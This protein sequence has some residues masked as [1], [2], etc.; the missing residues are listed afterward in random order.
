MGLPYAPGN[1]TELPKSEKVETRTSCKLLSPADATKSARLS[2]DIPRLNV[3]VDEVV[4][5]S[6]RSKVGL[7]RNR[8]IIPF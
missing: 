2:G 1:T 4:S 6:K 3:F 8:M 5:E 7:Y